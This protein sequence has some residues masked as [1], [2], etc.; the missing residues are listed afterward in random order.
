[1]LINK[2]TEGYVVQIFDT[3]TRKYVSQQFTADGPVNYESTDGQTPIEDGFMESVN[4]GPYAECEPYLPFDML[5]PSE[6]A[7]FGEKLGTEK[8]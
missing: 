6:M 5:Q 1:M 7:H 2:V 4:F 3:E 8:K